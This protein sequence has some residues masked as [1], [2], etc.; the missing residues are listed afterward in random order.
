MDEFESIDNEIVVLAQR[1]G[2]APAF[3]SAGTFGG[4]EGGAED[5]DDDC[6]FDGWG[7]LHTRLLYK[8]L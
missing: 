8:S 6:G 1:H 5:A 4:V 3:P 2:W 7:L